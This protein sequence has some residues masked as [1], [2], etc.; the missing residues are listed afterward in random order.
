M[1]RKPSWIWVCRKLGLRPGDRVLDIGCGWGSFAKY[2]TEK[3]GVEVVGITVSA[4]Q[5]GTREGIMQGLPV[6]IRLQD[7]RDVNGTFDHIVSIGMFEHVGYKNY[8]TYM[9]TVHGCLKEDGLFLLQTIGN[10]QTMT[11]NDPWF[12]EIHFPQLTHS[13][14]ETDQ[15]FDRRT[16]CC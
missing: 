5:S 11:A 1:R 2:S 6:E 14:D 10:K 15:R 9:K 3:Y 7:Y 4:E 8:K 12:E 16:I 13:V